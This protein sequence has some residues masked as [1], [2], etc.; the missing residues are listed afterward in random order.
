[1]ENNFASIR[2]ETTRIIDYV[3]LEDLKHFSMDN[4]AP[5]LQKSTYFHTPPSGKKMASTEQHQYDRSDLQHCTKI[6]FILRRTLLSCA[7][8][9][10]LGTS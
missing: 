5:R 3:D 2:W 1:M 6:C 4:S 9:V 8:K 7:L 10:Q